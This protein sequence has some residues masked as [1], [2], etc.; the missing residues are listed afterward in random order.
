VA[1]T[2]APRTPWR[3]ECATAP[4]HRRGSGWPPLPAMGSPA[5]S[6]APARGPRTLKIRPAMG[7][8]PC[9]AR[10]LPPGYRVA[11]LCFA[12]GSTWALSTH[13]RPCSLRHV[14][15]L[16]RSTSIPKLLTKNQVL[17]ERTYIGRSRR[18]KSSW[19]KSIGT[20]AATDEHAHPWTW[21]QRWDP[22]LDNLPVAARYCL[23]LRQ[24]HHIDRPCSRCSSRRVPMILHV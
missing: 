21:S 4:G 17:C 1:P 3:S 20:S 7:S 22:A 18:T 15:K 12:D 24:E 23:Q 11:W 14:W 19:P 13:D 10:G 8:S 6:E 5:V 16:G 9:W 2:P